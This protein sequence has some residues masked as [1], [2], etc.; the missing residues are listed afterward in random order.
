MELA[1][2]A[3]LAAPHMPVGLPAPSGTGADI[4]AWLWA[5]SAHLPAAPTLA[6]LALFLFGATARPS[7]I[8]RRAALRH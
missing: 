5:Q 2:A 7:A 4:L 8:R 3:R 6:V 1:E